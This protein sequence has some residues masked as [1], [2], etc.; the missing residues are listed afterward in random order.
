MAVRKRNKVVLLLTLLFLHRADVTFA[1]NDIIEQHKKRVYDKTLSDTARARA[2]LA[3]TMAWPNPPFEEAVPLLEQAYNIATTYGENKLGAQL[4]GRK[5]TYYINNNK[6]IEAFRVCNDLFN[7]AEKNKDTASLAKAYFYKGNIFLTY[8]M[9]AKAIEAQQ[10]AV[11]LALLMNDNY[12]KASALYLLGWYQFNNKQYELALKNFIQS[13][14]FHLANKSSYY[15]LGES[16]GWIGNAYSG[17]NMFDS[18]LYYRRI[19]TYYFKNINDGYGYPDSYRYIGNI[20]RKMNLLDSALYYYNTAHKMFKERKILERQ[21][22]LEYFIAETYHARK[23]YAMASRYLDTLL[24]KQTGTK[25]LLSMYLGTKLG[26]IV[27]EQNAEYKK[28]IECYKDFIQYKDSM[29]K[30]EQ[31]GKITELD[32]RL[33]FEKEQQNLLLEQEKKEALAKKDKETQLVVRNF[34]LTG[35]LFVLGFA[36]LIYRNY[37]SKQKDNVLLQQQK[38]EIEYRKKEIQDSINYARHIQFAVLPEINDIKSFF[39]ES[40]VFYKPKDVVSGDFF[41]ICNTQQQLLLATADCTGHGVPGAFMSMIGMYELNNTVLEKRIQEPAKI[42]S[43]VNMSLKK[44]LKQEGDEMK[45]RDGMDI[46]LCAFDKEKPIVHFSGANRPLYMIRNNN[47]IE[48][49]PTKAAIGG[50]TPHDKEFENIEIELQKG[51]CLYLYTDGY[52]DQYGGEKRKKLTTKKFKQFLLSVSSLSM[53]E[54]HYK[55]EEF[56]N[57]WKND[58][59]QIDDILVIGIR[60]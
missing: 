23:Q 29:E 52:A 2:V 47:P 12:E 41:W 17:I 10:K 58:I 37:K 32:A 42:L 19:S 21:W 3:Y 43:A 13:Y 18:A 48:Y 6:G 51:D 50:Y 25:D 40:F 44:R 31:A 14:Q 4:L 53:S 39:K 9:I 15:D 20:Y 7:D 59:E 57:F 22:L 16:S 36:F 30:T 49:K 8:N 56:L 45:S 24:N 26:G 27:Y 34:L 55:L 60:V 33:D 1:Q 54:Q 38:A 35:F 5:I 11:E 28:S 46:A